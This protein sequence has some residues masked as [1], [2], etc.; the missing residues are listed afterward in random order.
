MIALCGRVGKQM[1]VVD[2]TR[3]VGVCLFL[4]V[5]GA[6]LLSIV[7]DEKHSGFYR[8]MLHGESK[9]EIERVPFDQVYPTALEAFLTGEMG[10]F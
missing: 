2:G 5:P 8:M 9:A 4:D 6:P 7:L 3:E 10:S 1:P